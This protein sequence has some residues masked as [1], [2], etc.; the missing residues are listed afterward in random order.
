MPKS[1][2]LLDRQARL[3]GYLTSSA[4]IY[5][6]GG[7]PVQDAMLHGIDCWALHLVARFAHEKRME[8]IAAIFPR[9]LE[10]LSSNGSAI[11][12]EFAQAC[13][14]TG[15]GRI[16]NA[17]QFDDFLSAGL[18]DKPLYPEHLQDVAAC[19]LA[20]ANARFR[21]GEQAF[22]PEKTGE[23]Q[24]GWIR[25]SVGVE[26][27][28]CSYDLRPVFEGGWGGTAPIQRDTLLAITFVSGATSPQI[29]ELS[30]VAFD[31]LAKLDNWIDPAK[32][33][34]ESPELKELLCNLAQSGLVEPPP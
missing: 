3:L 27:L 6:D 2:P 33:I 8:K 12:E 16:E 13:P 31:L 15:T 21:A 10:I 25:R 24:Q 18:R 26:L 30:P 14:P 22:Q 1:Y 29:F 5:G 28:R 23:P 34:S 4:A 32:L 9:T 17:R 20:C 7:V 11:I 19:E